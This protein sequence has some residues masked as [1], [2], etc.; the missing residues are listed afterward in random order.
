MDAANLLSVDV[1]TLF[2]HHSVPE[3]DIVH[4]KIQSVVENKR[5]ELRLMVGERYRDLLQAADTIVAMRD[6]SQ[7]LTEQV[8]SISMNCRNL[9]DQQLLGFKISEPEDLLR[10]R[11]ANKQLNNYFSTMLQIKLLTTLP[12]LIW[13]HID[14]DRFY[15]ASELFIFSRHVSTGLQLDASNML[16]QHLPV[17]KKQWEILKP[18][19]MTIK[20]HVLAT[21]EKEDL[22]VNVATDCLLSLLILEKNS[23]NS[24]LKTFLNLR[25]KTFLNCLSND[26]KQST[27]ERER[28][29]NII[30]AS[31]RILN[32]T[33][34]IIE[35][36]FLE[37][38]LLLQRL[39]EHNDVNSSPI[40]TLVEEA[41]IVHSYL[42]PEIISNFRVRIETQSLDDTQVRESLEQWII[43]IRRI[44]ATQLK[45][46]FDYVSTMSV[47]K[48]IKIEANSYKNYFK[49]DQVVK[50]LK[51]TQTL[52]F[53]EQKYIP[54]INQRIHDIIHDNWAKAMQTTFESLEQ[55]LTDIN[56]SSLDIWY[57][58][59]NDLPSS[60]EVALSDDTKIKKMLMKTKGYDSDIISLC[61]EFD[62]KLKSI[63]SEM[64]V[65]LEE[66]ATR[67][68][69]K[70]S[71]IVFLRETSE[72]QLTHF[73]SRVKS[74]HLVPTQRS[75]LLFVA[76]CF[77][78][79]LELCPNLKTCFCQRGN[80]RQWVGNVTANSIEHWNRVCMLIEEET[81]IFWQQIVKGILQESNCEWNI[82]SSITNENILEEFANWETVEIDQKDESESTI[83]STFRIPNQ[84]RISLQTYLFTLVH[85]LNS[86]VPQTLPTKVLHYYNVNML[87]QILQQYQKILTD[88]ISSNQNIALQLYFDLKFLQTIFA[89][90]RD[91]KQLNDQFSALQGTC[92]SF[93]DPFDFELFS[94]PISTNVKRSIARYH[95]QFGVLT[96]PFPAHMA[97]KG[98]ANL[99]HEKDPNV[100]CLSSIGSSTA[101][102]PLLPIVTPASVEYSERKNVVENSEK[103]ASTA[104]HKA[105]SLTS[106]VTNTG[107]KVK[108]DSKTKSGAAS[109]FGAMSQDWFR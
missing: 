28:V 63:I 23:L 20:M 21:L 86:N 95:C 56:L 26:K 2:E 67:A 90:T 42:L 82:P 108:F 66:Q 87:A 91:D 8:D 97:P 44:A 78:A 50:R 75:E 109:F 35:K 59:I 93:I 33:I 36:C 29:Q 60:L 22:N 5:E 88:N 15:S 45:Q 48:E 92:K 37:N 81:L 43:D 7:R 71:L 49:F 1:D 72:A 68:E 102:F 41:D 3:I 51:L 74:L 61:A 17:A 62:E 55:S 39:Q 106:T 94:E 84:P 73:L 79:L 105:S 32:N 101:W 104:A 76:R 30:L 99:V 103:P 85:M 80:W 14:N 9:N 10:N 34:D 47:I 54:L 98:S 89:V 16:M 31:L 6:T 100:L 107:G 69:D 77:A 40:I 70:L 13:T 12:E 24:V 65:L 27:E 52:D 53:F 46:L 57:E 19:N 64:N 11:N 38:G 18:F 25:C 83:H 4:K 96:P 58:N